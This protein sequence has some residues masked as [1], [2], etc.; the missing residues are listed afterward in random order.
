MSF[1]YNLYGISNLIK[2]MRRNNYEID[3]FN[4]TFNAVEFNAIIDISVTPFQ[5]LLGTVNHNW[6]SVL[7]IEKGYSISMSNHDFISLCNIL[8]LKAG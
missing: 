4:F 3:E 1:Q 7:E 2:D 5:L 8:G 6:A